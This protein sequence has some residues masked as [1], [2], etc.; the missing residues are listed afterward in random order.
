MY[1]TGIGSS[2]SQSPYNRVNW[3]KGY[4]YWWH[5]VS[6]ARATQYEEHF[7]VLWGHNGCPAQCQSRS[8][9]GLVAEWH[10]KSFAHNRWAFFK[11]MFDMFEFCGTFNLK[12]NPARCTVFSTII[13]WCESVILAA[14]VSFN[15]RRIESIRS[16]K[17]LQTST[18]LSQFACAMQWMLAGIPKSL[19]I[20]VSTGRTS[21]EG[22]L[23][24]RKTQWPGNR[25]YLVD[26]N[27]LE[28]R[29]WRCFQTV[30]G[31]SKTASRPHTRQ[32]WK[33][34]QYVH[35]CVQI[36]ETI[37]APALYRRL[38]LPIPAWLVENNTMTP[39]HFFQCTCW[40]RL[41]VRQRA[42]ARCTQS[43]R[44]LI[45]CICSTLRRVFST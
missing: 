30:Q 18:D 5:L 6:N 8:Y 42:K 9:R 13:R 39:L 7:Y 19:A 32:F 34:S 17:A 31:R 36:R 20:Y 4:K 1:W 21:P 26:Q 27:C 12:A 25:L 43:C 24:C 16:I 10:P 2:C 3:L 11:A 29:M 35:R 37:F 33:A 44:R 45:K 41:S 23:C 28:V 38:E 22:L 15:P 40:T 14:S